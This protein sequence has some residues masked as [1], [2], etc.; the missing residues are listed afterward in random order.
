MHTHPSSFPASVVKVHTSFPVP[1][2]LHGV[3]HEAL[4]ATPAAQAGG[5]AAG[6]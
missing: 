6:W 4:S 2:P 1:A 3:V 5:E